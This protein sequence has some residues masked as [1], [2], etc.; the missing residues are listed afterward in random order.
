M[1]PAPLLQLLAHQFLV[2]LKLFFECIFSFCSFLSLSQAPSLL[3]NC[4]ACLILYKQ[5]WTQISITFSVFQCPCSQ[6]VFRTK[7]AVTLWQLTFKCKTRRKKTCYIPYIHTSIT[8]SISCIIILM[9]IA[10]TQRLNYSRQK[11]KKHTVKIS[12]TPVTLKQGQGH[13]AWYELV[14]PKQGYN[15]AKFERSCLNS[16]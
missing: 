5:M 14:D 4:F 12:D 7:R 6:M 2:F 15:H 9:Y 8:Q 13:K 10:T 11:S 16:A 1:F 3:G